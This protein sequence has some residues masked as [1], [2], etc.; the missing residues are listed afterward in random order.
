M[1]DHV[2]ELG[3]VAGIGAAIGVG[4]A[5]GMGLRFL[6]TSALVGIGAGAAVG[7]ATALKARETIETPAIPVQSQQPVLH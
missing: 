2:K 5:L 1:D 7:V 6:A 4:I 3:I